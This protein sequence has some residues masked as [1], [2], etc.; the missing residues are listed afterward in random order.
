[1]T[2]TVTANA[3]YTAMWKKI[4]IFTVT[5]TD[6]V[7]DE[8]IFKDQVSN[9]YRNDPSPVYNGAEPTRK[10]YLFK[11][12]SPDYIDVVTENTIYISLNGKR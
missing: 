3:T 2:E 8:E 7:A 6:G 1:M 5:Y 11:G 12:W 4:D 9:V 10:S